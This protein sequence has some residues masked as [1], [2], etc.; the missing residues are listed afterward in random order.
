MA[1]LE[2]FLDVDGEKVSPRLR[3]IL[4]HGYQLFHHFLIAL[5]EFIR[6][7][8]CIFIDFPLFI[9]SNIVKYYLDRYPSMRSKINGLC[10]SLRSVEQM[11]K[12]FG[13][14][15]FDSVVAKLALYRLE[16]VIKTSEVILK[17]LLRVIDGDNSVVYRCHRCR[18]LTSV[19]AHYDDA[20]SE[21]ETVQIRTQRDFVLT[22][23]DHITENGLSGPQRENLS[24]SLEK[25]AE[26]VS[27]ETK[28]AADRTKTVG[29]GKDNETTDVAGKRAKTADSASNN[30]ETTKAS[31]TEG[32]NTDTIHNGL[33]NAHTE[34]EGIEKFFVLFYK[35]FVLHPFNAYVAMLHFI[36]NVTFDVN[37][38]CQKLGPISSS[39]R[40]IVSPRRMIRNRFLL[41]VKKMTNE[42]VNLAAA[43]YRFKL[44]LAETGDLIINPNQSTSRKRKISLDELDACSRSSSSD[45]DYVP[46][47]PYSD[48]ESESLSEEDFSSEDT[49]IE[50]CEVP[51]D[52]H[53]AGTQT[54]DVMHAKDSNNG[55]KYFDSE[56][57]L[58]D[59]KDIE[60]KMNDAQDGENKMNEGVMN[61][62]VKNE[63]NEG[64]KNE[65]NEGV[66]NEMNEGVKNDMNEGVENEMN[67]SVE[68]EMNESVE[69]EMNEEW[70]SSKQ[71]L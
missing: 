2:L 46:E 47:I 38:Y 32:G 16:N 42:V 28:N 13:R 37:D 22:D 71:Y 53:G 44:I 6:I 1:P 36:R 15:L 11:F 54:A 19:S 45:P 4:L 24:T 66:K 41:Q 59:V 30:I 55:V 48:L 14:Y 7:I 65:M 57:K 25:A 50:D 9:C 21:D 49:E 17:R 33:I 35:T 12:N 64:V 27:T 58:N 62:G 61:E 5:Q 67:E 52:T 56:N 60:N 20:S 8:Y 40:K 3:Q 26:K 51:Q 43:D 23:A 70:Y 63:M 10:E 69:N 68:N 34:V 39:G 18:F 29:A 31:D